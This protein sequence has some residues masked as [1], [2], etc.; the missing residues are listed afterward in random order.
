MPQ[1]LG[2]TSI[3][4]QEQMALLQQQNES[5]QQ[6]QQQQ[7]A[8]EQQQP[9]QGEAGIPPQSSGRPEVGAAL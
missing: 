1:L 9:G 7:Q 3:L 8:A 2:E 4:L 5:I 6:E